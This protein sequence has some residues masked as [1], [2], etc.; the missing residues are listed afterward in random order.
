MPFGFAKQLKHQQPL[1]AKE[2]FE[3]LIKA[4]G[5][6]NKAKQT[7]TRLSSMDMKFPRKTPV[8]LLAMYRLQGS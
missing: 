4:A 1:A 6:V 5:S 2:V 8:V 7:T 3:V